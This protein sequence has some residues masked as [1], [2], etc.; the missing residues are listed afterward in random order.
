MNIELT[1]DELSAIYAALRYHKK[2]HLA[3][4]PFKGCDELIYN[5]E[6]RFCEYERYD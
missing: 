5:L 3:H 4:E 6:E 1:E 2:N